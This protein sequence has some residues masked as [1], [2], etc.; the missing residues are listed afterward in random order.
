[1]LFCK[2]L[3]F[4]KIKNIIICSY[5]EGIIK[6]GKM[7]TILKSYLNS[8]EMLMVIMLYF[9]SLQNLPYKFHIALS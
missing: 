4:E 5:S 2:F 6:H 7:K 9:F 8:P 1:M 3:Q